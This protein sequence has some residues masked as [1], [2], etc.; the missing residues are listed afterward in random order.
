VPRR[1]RSGRLGDDGRVGTPTLLRAEDARLAAAVA[2]AGRVLVDVGCGDGRH[3]LRWA[4]RE[5]DALVVGLD[6]E[7][8]RLDRA[9]GAARR[10]R[11]GRLLF[12]TAAAE[13]PPASLVG[14][15]DAIAVVMP[16]GSLLD[17]VLGGDEPV[18]AAVLGLGRPGSTLDAVVNVRPWDAPSSVDRKLAATPEPT[19]EH[20]R[21][22]AGRYAAYGWRLGPPEPVTDAEARALGST[23]ASRVVSARASRLVRLRAGRTVA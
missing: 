4:E 2:Q 17:G 22:L 15:A 14:R 20:L 3:T 13:D 9:L 18:L 7:T 1:Q 12:V 19:A 8:T 11:L 6:A 16:W 10:R 21:G 23:W 5:P